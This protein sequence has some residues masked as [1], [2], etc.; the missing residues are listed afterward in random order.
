M[1]ADYKSPA[2]MMEMVEYFARVSVDESLLSANELFLGQIY[3]ILWSVPFCLLNN[4]MYLLCPAFSINIL[5]TQAVGTREHLL[6]TIIPVYNTFNCCALHLHLA[7]CVQQSQKMLSSHSDSLQLQELIS[8]RKLTNDFSF[9]ISAKSRVQSEVSAEAVH[10][11][12]STLS[13][14]L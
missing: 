1:S 5:K 6:Q 3:F 14:A 7:Y 12:T 11:S 2:A 13:A 10:M 8:R 9:S 4:K